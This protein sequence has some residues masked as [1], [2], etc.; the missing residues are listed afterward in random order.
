MGRRWTPRPPRP[1]RSISPT[2]AAA[3]TNDRGDADVSRARRNARISHARRLRLTQVVCKR[4]TRTRSAEPW[5]SRELSRHSRRSQGAPRRRHHQPP[6]APDDGWGSCLTA[7]NP[8][9][10]G[11]VSAVNII[12]TVRLS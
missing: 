1:P 10:H 11:C 9:R 3:T 5:G 4:F 8:L 7:Q 6:R 12:E 2:R